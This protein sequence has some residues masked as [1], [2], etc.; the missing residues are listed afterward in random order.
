MTVTTDAPEPLVV[1]SP[2]LISPPDRRFWTDETMDHPRYSVSE[3]AKFFFAKGP[4]WLRWRENP[5]P[6]PGKTREE[7]EY[8]DGWFILDGEKLEPKRTDAGARYYRLWD[9]ERM[10]HALAQNEAIDGSVLQRVIR[11]IKTEAELYGHL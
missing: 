2:D 9:V 7:M 10:A 4:D 11:L 1:A 6:P 3:V 5:Q 8:P